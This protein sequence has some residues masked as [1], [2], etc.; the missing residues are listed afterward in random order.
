MVWL[1]RGVAA[2]L[3]CCAGLLLTPDARAGHCTY[4]TE[5]RPHDVLFPLTEIGSD[6]VVVI[7]LAD[8]SGRLID[9]SWWEHVAVSITDDAGVPVDGELELHSGFTPATWRPSQPWIPGSF[10]ARVDVNLEAGG[11]PCLP[12][13]VVSPFVVLDTPTAPRPAFTIATSETYWL[14]PRPELS[15]LVCCDGALPYRP[16]VPGVVCPSHSPPDPEVGTGFCAEL[17][18]RGRLYVETEFE[19][20]V[21]A[22]SPLLAVRELTTGDRPATSGPQATVVLSSPGC[23]ELEVLDLVSGVR[24]SFPSCHGD[25][26][27]DQLGEVALDPAP[28]LV[29]SCV[30]D[31]YVCEVAYD[32][33]DPNACTRWPDGA[34]FEPLPDT[35][36]ETSSGTDPGGDADA[37]NSGGGC[38]LAGRSAH[39]GTWLLIVGL[40]LR[41]RSTH[42]G[43]LRRS[44]VG[45]RR[46]ELRSV[47]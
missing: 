33:W 20:V 11:A 9:E 14:D 16:S 40:M 5:S 24:T 42:G 39:S 43:A 46:R 6:G 45:L 35:S 17:I 47:G 2:G 26:I 21:V 4:C 29:E 44:G 32:R 15:T 27:G 28:A 41:R 12:I 23:I 8:Y 31:P 34:A 19:P 38:S 7:V 10:E 37:E 18:G 13:E 30:G 1:G 36:S 3:V 25:A 22:D